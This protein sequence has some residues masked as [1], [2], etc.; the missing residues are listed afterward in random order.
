M[1]SPLPDSL[2]CALLGRALTK[3][4]V[5]ARQLGNRRRM[6]GGQRLGAMCDVERQPDRDVRCCETIKRLR[7]GQRDRTLDK[8]REPV[9]L[10]EVVQRGGMARDLRAGVG[11]RRDP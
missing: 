11:L 3:Q 5:D 6:A 2:T 4:R 7:L 9:A 10:E 1:L 8:A